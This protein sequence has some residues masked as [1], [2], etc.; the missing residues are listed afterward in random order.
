M[1]EV[2]VVD[3]P[4]PLD[5][6]ELGAAELSELAERRADLSLHVVLPES[7]FTRA[8]ETAETPVDADDPASL[9]DYLAREEYQRSLEGYRTLGALALASEV[10]TSEGRLAKEALRRMW[11]TS[12]AEILENDEEFRGFFEI[13]DLYDYQI[14]DGMVMAAP[15]KPMAGMVRDGARKSRVEAA[16]DP[17]MKTQAN[18]DEA[19][20]YNAERVDQ[21]VAGET[22][23]NTRF[24]ISK[25]PRHAL[26]ADPEFWKSKGYREG[27]AFGQLYYAGE[28]M[29]AGTFSID[30][31]DDAVFDQVLGECGVAIPEGRISDYTVLDGV[32][33]TFDNR[34]QAL[35]FVREFRAR[36]YALQGNTRHRQSVNEFMNDHASRIDAAFGALCL[37]LAESVE[38]GRKH[39]TIHTFAS[40]LLQAEEDLKPEVVAQLRTICAS[41]TFTDDDGRLMAGLTLYAAAE[42]L[43][44]DARRLVKGEASPIKNIAMVGSGADIAQ[45]LAGRVRMG[46][47]A[48]RSHGSSCAGVTDISNKRDKE[49]G[50]DDDLLNPQ[51]AYGGRD[52]SET[53]RIPAQIRCIKCRKYS[54]REKVV[55]T[56]VRQPSKD[57]WGC[58]HCRYKIDVCTGKVLRE[59]N[60]DN[61]N[62][63]ALGERLLALVSQAERPDTPQSNDN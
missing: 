48:G 45:H 50:I 53:N 36:C 31:V 15:G 43:Y 60:I 57:Y 30:N 20:V 13:N 8:L 54:P 59:S 40:G 14:H 25:S 35:A 18:R 51:D 21:I 9:P 7:A 42:E 52:Q 29:L 1:G 39:E 12:L 16:A 26:A 56:N 24:V 37:P 19:D 11:T 63:Q 22:S 10:D 62:S 38:S 27:L 49:T 58:P 46:V 2:L 23:V 44:E 47:E 61:D 41:E 34:E 28:N 32:E 6:V 3:R 55:H 33:R 4:A 5:V 17:R